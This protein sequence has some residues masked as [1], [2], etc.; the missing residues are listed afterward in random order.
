MKEKIVKL[1]QEK[2]KSLAVESQNIDYSGNAKVISETLGLSRNW[3]SQCLN[4]LF[5]EG[6]LL[7]IITRPVLYF[8]YEAISENFAVEFDQR[9]FSSVD[10]FFSILQKNQLHDF[11]KMIG[12]NGSLRSA[13][14]QCKA[15]V[16]Y[17]PNGLPI[18]LYGP[19]GTGK[20]FIAKMMFEYAQN[21][22][23]VEKDKRFIHI[24]CSEYTNNPE[25]FNANLYGY[26]KGAFTGA[27]KDHLGM[28]SVA[29]GGVLFLD[30]IHCLQP[31]CQE[32][33]FLFM[34]NGSYHMVGD[35]ESWQ[36]SDAR[37]IFATTEDPEKVL[38]KT[39]LRRIPMIVT[40]PSLVERGINEKVEY[41]VYFLKREEKRISKKIFISDAFYKY[42]INADFSDNVGGVYNAIQSSVV[43]AFYRSRNDQQK[44]EI[45]AM[46][47]QEFRMKDTL[48]FST[49]YT[50]ST[51]KTMISNVDFRLPWRVAHEGDY[52]LEELLSWI[53]AICK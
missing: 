6:S 44:I 23:I 12:I 22:K 37:L 15:T 3:I 21:Q 16:S 4:E 48:T 11:E 25:L 27:D 9:L 28:I 51:V 42:L 49:H 24:N 32:K 29:D 53:D 43:N 50:F 19:T 2:S 8:D 38:L 40:I 1:I 34:D 13:A 7:K 5:E 41:I 36:H 45:T 31:A 30:E 33:L 35:N 46:D 10:E 18:L 20:S 26:K 17:P 39:F 47:F 52:D 14:N